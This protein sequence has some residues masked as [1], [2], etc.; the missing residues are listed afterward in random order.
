MQNKSAIFYGAKKWLRPT[1]GAA[2]WIIAGFLPILLLAGCA[3]GSTVES[4]KKA[5]PAAYAALSPDIKALVDQGRV[6]VGMTP[7]AV[8]LAWGPPEEV[9]HRGNKDGEF[10]TWVYRGSYL[11][12]TRYWVGRRQPHLA[13]DYQP[14]TYAQSEI[15][16]ANGV[17]D[18]WQTRSQPGN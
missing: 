10:T 7:D 11:E 3:T 6:A 8:T 5:N 9:L 15:V 13:Y 2:R 14:R 1:T 17:V 12:E 16:F 4:R 18:S